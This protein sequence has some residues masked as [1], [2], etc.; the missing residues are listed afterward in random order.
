MLQGRTSKVPERGFKQ[1][2]ENFICFK[3]L[4]NLKGKMSN[5]AAS[6]TCLKSKKGGILRPKISPVVY[7]SLKLYGFTMWN[8]RVAKCGQ[9]NLV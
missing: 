8:R 2:A 1:M 4:R 3:V 9:I 5:Y 7:L 6:N